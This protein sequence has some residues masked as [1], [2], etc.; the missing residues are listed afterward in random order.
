MRK[1][2][3]E[4]VVQ[5]DKYEHRAQMKSPLAL[6]D[7]VQD[8]D[9]RA[10]MALLL[11]GTLE[12]FVQ[13]LTR[14]YISEVCS[15]GG[16]F[17]NLPRRMQKSHFEDGAHHLIK[18]TKSEW[19]EIQAGK[20]LEFVRAK[21]VCRRLASAN[22]ARYE[23]V[24]EAFA[25]TDSNAGPDTIALVLTRLDVQ[26]PWPTIETNTPASAHSVPSGSAR[27]S[28]LIADLRDLREARNRC[29]HGAAS[30]AAPAWS[31]LLDYVLA[32][33]VVGEGMVNLLERHLLTMPS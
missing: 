26:K 33:R 12:A 10:A 31:L 14:S 19:G 16:D 11:S 13:H 3:G 30:E 23:L 15:R 27:E 17:N 22:L 2:Y 20:A 9:D 4:L 6:K 28:K 8:T 7:P 18:V 1:V 25:R 32:V 29:A 21:D 24:W 5:L